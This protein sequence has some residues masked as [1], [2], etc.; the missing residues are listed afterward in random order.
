MKTTMWCLIDKTLGMRSWR[1]LAGGR[2][3]VRGPCNARPLHRAPLEVETLENRVVPSGLVLGTDGNLW[4]EAPS[5]QTDGRLLIDGNVRGFQQGND[6]YIYVLG[7]DGKLWQ[8][9]PY[10]QFTNGRT[11]VDGNVRSFAHGSDGYDYVLGSDGNL[12]Q[13]QPGWQINGRTWVDGHVR[14]FAHGDDGNDYVLGTDLNL[15]QEQPGWQTQGRTWVD[16]DVRGSEFGSDVYCLALGPR[17]AAAVAYSPT[18]GTLFGP[19]GP[20]YLDVQQGF[21]GDCW[22]IASLSEVAARAPSDI[23]SMFTYD[24]T[25]VVGGATSSAAVDIHTVRLYDNTGVAQYFTVDT[26]LPGGGT[27]YDRPVGG[28]GA[29]NCSPSPVLWVAIAEK[30]Y[31]EANAYGVV[32]TGQEGL[33]SYAALNNGWPEWALGAITGKSTTAHY[34]INPTDV[35][36]AWNAGELVVLCTTSPVSSYIV[37]SHCYALVNYN[38]STSLS[39]ELMNPWGTDANG[40][41][42]G[43]SGS[44]YGLFVANAPFLSQN[45]S[46]QSYGWGGEASGQE[47]QH[48]R[49]RQQLVDLAFVANLMETHSKSRSASTADS[50]LDSLGL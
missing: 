43:Y 16:G 6:G 12:W 19:G 23:T 47:G 9:F 17:P 49:S 29:V 48:T 31:V 4:K 45:F 24:G 50:L 21:V 22:L 25:T 28:P 42:P 11:W 37:G 1:W 18:N 41:A 35:A 15:W 39:F 14:A 36:S 34:A 32:T 5:W 27:Y 13:E 46:S 8:E 38:Q 30:A 26:E 44:K 7:T 10:W 33:D 40:W 20:S 2:D 3:R